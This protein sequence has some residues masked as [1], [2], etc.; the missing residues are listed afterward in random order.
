MAAPSPEVAKAKA[1]IKGFADKL[2]GELVGAMQS[3]GPVA[4]IETCRAV[5]PGIAK[6][7]SAPADGFVIGRTALKVRNSQ[8]KPDAFEKKVLEDF[9]AKIKGGADPATLEHTE[10]VEQNGVK[11]VRFMKAIPMAEAPCMACHGPSEKIDP[12][13]AAKIKQLYPS[14]EA[15]GFK[16]GELR[17]AFTVTIKK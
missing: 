16:P 3:G 10:E 15:V 12:A 14:D 4:A 1:A 9:V 6:D 8:N 5:A 2:R 7:A 11:H 17:G 13:A